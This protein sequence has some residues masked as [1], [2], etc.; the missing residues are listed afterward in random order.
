[1]KR[2]TLFEKFSKENE[3]EKQTTNRDNC[4]KTKRKNERKRQ[5]RHQRKSKK[6][7]KI[8]HLKESKKQTKHRMKSK[9]S[10]K[11]QHHMIL[12][13][14][15]SRNQRQNFAFFLTK[16]RK[17]TNI[18]TD[19]ETLKRLKM[20]VTVLIKSYFSTNDIA[21]FIDELNKRKRRILT[22]ISEILTKL[23]K[24][25]KV[26]FFERNFHSHDKKNSDSNDSNDFDFFFHCDEY[27]IRP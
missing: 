6:S 9:K 4:S 27:S 23:S 1:M 12:R 14:K 16:K 17:N 8:R 15:I 20:I 5:I 7:R 22:Q 3:I 26:L 25:W 13:S 11:R 2:K 18:D 10:K 24:R 21:E 19:I